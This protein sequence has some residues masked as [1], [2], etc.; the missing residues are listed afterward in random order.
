MTVMYKL[1]T[2]MLVPFLKLFWRWRFIDLHKIPS[3]GPVII[4]ANHISYFDPLCHAICVHS[5][6]RIMRV[7]AKAELWRNPVLR[8]I[9]KGARMIPVERGSG[10]AGPVAAAEQVLREGGLV[11]LYPEATLSKNPDLM[12]MRGKTG[13][14]RAALATGAIVVPVAVWGSQWVIPPGSRFFKSIR[15]LVLLKVGEPMR[16]DDLV[17]R[18]DDPEVRRDVTD[19]VMKELE[20]LVR[21]LQ[22]LHPRGAAVPE[23]RA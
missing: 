7:F 23:R 18:Q 15:T 5:S 2:W 11:M 22:E 9:L 21:D 3:D 1:V 4:A 20:L 17:G 8:F 6:G 16:F 19:R 12:P 10:D 13:V 14:A